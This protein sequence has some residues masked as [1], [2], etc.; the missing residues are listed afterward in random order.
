MGVPSIIKRGSGRC[1][2]RG[3]IGNINGKSREFKKYDSPN[4]KHSGLLGE[5]ISLAI[6]LKINLSSILPGQASP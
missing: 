3:L 6:D 4:Q 1:H 2:P 5:L